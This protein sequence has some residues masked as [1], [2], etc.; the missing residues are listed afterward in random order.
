MVERAVTSTSMR[1][2]AEWYHMDSHWKMKMSSSVR[3]AP[4]YLKSLSRYFV[5]VTYHGSYIRDLML[6]KSVGATQRKSS[7]NTHHMTQPMMCV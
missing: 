1:V 4:I 3:K 2:S 7:L 5:M 6:P